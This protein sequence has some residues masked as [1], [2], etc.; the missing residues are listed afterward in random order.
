MNDSNTPVLIVGGSIVGVSAAL[1]LAARGIRPVLVE[2]HREISTRL[3]AKLFYPRTMEAYRAV[4]ADRDVYALQDSLPPAD[5]AAV[6][7]SLAGRELRRWRLPAAAD[8]TDV[9]PCPSALVKQADLVR[10]IRAHARDASA[11]LRFG[12][13]FLSMTQREDRVV[14]QIAGPDGEPYTVEARWLIAAD[15]NTSGIRQALGIERSGDKTGSDIREIGFHADLRRILEDRRLA[16]AW[17]GTTF[18]S[19]TT[20]QD[21][22]AVSFSCNPRTPI[23]PRDCLDIVG[24]ALGLPTA[25][26]TITG[27]RSWRMS[28]Q[29]AGSFRAG[30]VF[31]TGDAAHVTP[32]VGGFGANLGVQDAWNLSAKLIAV[33]RGDAD[34]QLLDQYE[35]ERRTVAELTVEQA[36]R[37]LRG[38]AGDT[39][40]E[41]ALHSEAAIAIGYRYPVPGHDD[42]LPFADEPGRW[43]GEPGTR[44]PHVR[45]DAGS[46]L[47]LVRDGRYL[48]LAGADRADLARVVHDID[49]DGSFLDLA[50]VQDAE[51]SCGIGTTG[52]LL[53]RPD[54]VVA[55]HSGDAA[56]HGLADAVATALGR[57]TPVA[58]ARRI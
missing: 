3:R 17:A 19:W 57:A 34:P 35:P 31:L 8:F 6:V 39:T 23:R 50:V 30:R 4:G 52:A 18:L 21:G 26:I 16:M 32:P 27:T 25:D 12:H 54:H 28:S 51:D 46:T 45:L 36:V 20:A 10:I 15:G 24:R 29:V 38:R 22:G 1:F 41:A 7:E 43:R 55:W 44:L 40:R 37:R 5:H 2:K 58:V 13:R 47:D 53:V 11:D 49:P 42:D 56:T 14:A 48:L 33:L 9:S